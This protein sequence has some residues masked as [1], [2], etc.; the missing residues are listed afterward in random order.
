[1]ILADS[2][3]L[4]SRKKSSNDKKFQMKKKKSPPSDEV[5]PSATTPSPEPTVM[6]MN[7]MLRQFRLINDH[8]SSFETSTKYDINARFD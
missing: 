3:P 8:I 7:G 5:A 6:S 1:M 4:C 2:H